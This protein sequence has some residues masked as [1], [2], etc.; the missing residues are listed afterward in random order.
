MPTKPRIVISPQETAHV[1]ALAMDACEALGHLD[2]DGDG[3]ESARVVCAWLEELHGAVAL[4]AERQLEG[5][6]RLV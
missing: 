2:P 1:L 6:L 5:Q 4:R 3:H